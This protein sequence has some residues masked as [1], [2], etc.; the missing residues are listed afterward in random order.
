LPGADVELAIALVRAA[1]AAVLAT[2]R[3]PVE[4][5]TAATDVVTA[6]DR[7]AEAAM[8]ELLARERPD[9]G[10]VGEEGARAA[11]AGRTWILDALDGTLNYATGLGPW[12]C[13]AA[14]VADDRPLAVGV[15]DPVAGVLWSAG[16][17][18]GAWRDD[19]PLR[20]RGPGR[21]ADAIVATYAHPDRKGRPGV[22]DGFR[23]LV[24]QTG[25]V[26]IA[27]SGTLDL[28]AVADGRQH[29][30]VQP[31]VEPWD[32]HP[33]A[34]LVTEA[35]GAT[36]EAVREGTPWRIAAASAEL[37]DALVTVLSD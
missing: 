4:A 1:G 33:G 2:G 27:G 37:R 3:G 20:T 31:A 15:L 30:W 18:E 19:T 5:K 8:V 24:E 32:W 21:L 26:R 35:G 13:A 16:A 14:L 22:L 11:G 34:L 17:G 36:G 6:A 25:L 10:I 29:G 12:C 23:A 7:A 9:D 28:A